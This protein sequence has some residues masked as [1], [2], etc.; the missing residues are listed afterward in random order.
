MD[1][2]VIVVGGGPA[3]RLAA[4]AIA[5][6][7]LEVALVARDVRASWQNNYGIWLDELPDPALTAALERSWERPLVFLDDDEPLALG[8]AYG[9]FDNARFC[10]MLDAKVRR[11][12]GRLIDGDVLEARHDARGS[13]V[14]MS[15][16]RALSAR[17]IVDATGHQ[18]RLVEAG[19]ALDAGGA[20]QVAYGVVLQRA[21]LPALPLAASEMVLMDF[22]DRC[23]TPDARGQATFLYAMPLPGGRLFV[24]E[25]SLVS[26]PPLPFA[27][28][29]ERLH[30][31]L[32]DLGVA[33]EGELGCLVR[34]PPLGTGGRGG[35]RASPERLELGSA[36]RPPAAGPAGGERGGVE[37]C[38]IPM[39]APHPRLDQRVI[40]FGGA[41]AMVHPATG[42]MIGQAIA[43]APRLAEAIASAARRRA[44]DAAAIARAGWRAIWPRERRRAWA[45]YRV[46]M[47]L[48]LDL[49]AR[50]TRQFFLAFF[51]APR[52]RWSSFL[53]ARAPTREILA[54]MSAVLRSAPSSLRRK[55]LAR[56]MGRIGPA[57]VGWG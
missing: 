21:Q 16:G 37:R 35:E 42:Y 9:R 38:W 32:E 10:A 11:G 2:D 24:E 39:G 4:A 18:A 7:G 48:L 40:G 3:G 54:T 26:R 33:A 57:L 22:R 15:G 29:A 23:G 44:P 50:E 43:H 19:A 36:G 27:L 20:A 14:R 49:D 6:A 47:E 53:S 51:A 30:A 13:T 5:E 8:R 31:R 12:G 46:G 1:T 25:T 41:A 34:Q 52:S 28:L 45:L 17:V 56:S 55:I